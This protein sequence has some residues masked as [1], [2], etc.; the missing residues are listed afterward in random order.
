MRQESSALEYV[1]PM[2]FA[3]DSLKQRIRDIQSD[4]EGQT[5]DIHTCETGVPIEQIA[6]VVDEVFRQNYGLASWDGNGDEGDDLQLCVSELT[7]A[8]DDRVAESLVKHLIDRDDYWPPDGGEPFYDDTETYKEGDYTD[9][10]HSWLWERFRSLILHDQRFFN[11]ASADML[12]QIFDNI[13]L[14]LNGEGGRP[15]YMIQP[16]DEL[17]RFYRARVADDET[18][19]RDIAKDVA[20]HLGPPPERLRRAGRM[21]PA[22]ITAFYG[23]FDLDTCIAELWPAVGSL[24]VGARFELTEPL[25]VLDIT[26][27]QKPQIRPGL[28]EKNQVCLTA[29]WRFMTQFMREI[30][31]PVSSSDEHLEYIPTQAV[32]EYLSHQHEFVYGDRKM[33]VE[34]VVYQSAQYPTGKNIAILG[35]AATVGVLDE[36]KP[37]LIGGERNTNQHT[38]ERRLFGRPKIRVAA[39]PDTLE[40][41]RIT[42]AAFSSAPHCDGPYFGEPPLDD[43]PF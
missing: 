27:F 19:R 10:S 32:A 4:Y 37:A 12:K 16:G 14:Q 33:R 35:A 2:C 29:Q 8:T 15:V 22:G 13:H 7:G 24:V 42:G 38:P 20:L 3:D 17:S 18:S 43:L 9:A 21:N 5:C 26:Q 40:I 31:Q 39:K 36:D 11:A 28:F 6:T 25:C 23:A 1:C 41:R 30:S 34:A